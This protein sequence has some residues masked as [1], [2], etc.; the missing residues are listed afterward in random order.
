MILEYAKI[1][2]DVIDP[3]R[4]N[5]SDAGLDVYFNPGDG[6]QVWIEPGESARM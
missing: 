1:R 6:R 5:P 4:A 2:P 3:D